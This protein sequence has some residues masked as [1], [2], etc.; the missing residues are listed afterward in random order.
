MDRK[1]IFL[2]EY[3]FQ[4][5]TDNLSDGSVDLYNSVFLDKP[6]KLDPKC[7]IE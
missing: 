7:I 4:T 2:L 6:Y 1:I 5:G 3:N